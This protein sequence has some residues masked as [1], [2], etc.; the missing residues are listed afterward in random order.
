MS[1][2]LQPHIHL[3]RI[4]DSVIVLDV[5]HD[6]YFRAEPAIAA[7]LIAIADEPCAP[8]NPAACRA[9]LATGLL[10]STRSARAVAFARSAPPTASALEERGATCALSRLGVARALIAAR[11]RLRALGLERTLR[12]AAASR[13]RD[14]SDLDGAAIARGFEQARSDL[15][16]SRRCLPDSL[17]LLGMTRRL[18]VRASLVIGV[19]DPPFAAHA[20]VEAG[21]LVL[22]DALSVVREFTPIL[23]L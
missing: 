22:S 13:P 19:N 14:P 11:L 4:G 10:S 16:F 23:R 18:G 1:L 20:W 17:A 21:P 12:H 6:R 3:A 15:P 7:A 9:L 2:G 8:A 5:R